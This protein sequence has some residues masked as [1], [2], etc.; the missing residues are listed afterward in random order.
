MGREVCGACRGMTAEA[1]VSSDS[2]ASAYHECDSIVM[3]LSTSALIVLRPLSRLDYLSP[4]I[5]TSA[6]PPNSASRPLPLPDQHY[7][8]QSHTPQLCAHDIPP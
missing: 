4:H 3:P 2:E 1:V 8:S 7:D 6:P 5:N